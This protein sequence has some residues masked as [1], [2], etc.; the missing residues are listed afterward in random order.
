[1]GYIL[2]HYIPCCLIVF[3]KA[4]IFSKVLVS[5]DALFKMKRK[6]EQVVV[7]LHGNYLFLEQVFVTSVFAYQLDAYRNNKRTSE[8][9]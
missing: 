4:L 3:S 8:A 9:L 5:V 7:Y 1:M 2:Q 6:W